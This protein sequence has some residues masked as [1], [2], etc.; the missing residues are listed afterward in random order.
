MCR[1]ARD[2]GWPYEDL[3]REL[4]E[5]EIDNSHQSTA[6]RLLREPRFPDVK[7]FDRLEWTE[8]KGVSRPKLMQLASC[9]FIGRAGPIGIGKTHLVISPGLE[10]PGR[11]LRVHFDR[12]AD[13]Y[14]A[15]LREL[16]VSALLPG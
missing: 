15:W 2:C 10:A 7:T 11:R 16:K 1:R 13:R 4:L 12:A 8:L 5:A 6:R 9:N 14:K 3:L